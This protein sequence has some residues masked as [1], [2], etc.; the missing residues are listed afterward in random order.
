M[1]ASKPFHPS[2]LPRLALP[3][4]IALLA[5]CSTAQY[6]Q[7]PAVATLELK[8]E[9]NIP[10]TEGRV[11]L[12]QGKV[13]PGMPDSYSPHCSLEMY[14]LNPQDFSIAPG[15]YPITHI[16]LYHTEV[17][18]LKP[19]SYA[20]ASVSS[21]DSSPSDIMLGFHFWFADSIGAEPRRMTCLGAL[22]APWE[23][24]EPS[25]AEI[26]ALLGGL[27]RLTLHSRH[28]VLR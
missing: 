22:A 9:I 13:L 14:G 5:A 8:Q 28:G 16:Q 24:N 3:L 7:G 12:Q 4:A 27:G 10:A 2:R 21:D 20:A 17:V 19:V 1:S 25:L 15:D 11:F 6:R 23:A 26:N 18:M